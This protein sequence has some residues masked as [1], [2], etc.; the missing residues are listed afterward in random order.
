[1]EEVRQSDLVFRMGGDEVLVLC[2]ATDLDQAGE[3]LHRINSRLHNLL[4]ACVDEVSGEVTN[5]Q[6][7]ISFGV[8]S[9]L[10]QGAGETVVLADKRMYE[11]KKQ[12]YESGIMERNR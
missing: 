11:K 10:E 9:S 4:V 5:E 8:A 12:W 7:Y 6:V 2:P 1:M 3:L